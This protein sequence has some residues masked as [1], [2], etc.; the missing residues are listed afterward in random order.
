MFEARRLSQQRTS[1]KTPQLAPNHQQNKSHLI[2]SSGTKSAVHHHPASMSGSLAQSKRISFSDMQQN[3]NKVLSNEGGADEA[4][5]LYC[6]VD[7]RKNS[8][9][10]LHNVPSLGQT[11]GQVQILQVDAQGNNKTGG[12]ALNKVQL[13]TKDKLQNYN[14][15]PGFLSQSPKAKKHSA[16]SK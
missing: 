9:S 11:L 13:K 3:S 5:K 6:M 15:P 10:S 7:S 16:S 14:K 2:D 12:S 4:K 1:H 8:Q